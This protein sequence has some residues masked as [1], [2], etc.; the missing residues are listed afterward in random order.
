MKEELIWT[1]GEMIMTGEIEVLGQET[2][3]L[4]LYPP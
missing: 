1:T 3:P 4:T 2:V